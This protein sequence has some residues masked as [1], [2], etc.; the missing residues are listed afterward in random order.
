MKVAILNFFIIDEELFPFLSRVLPVSKE[1]N[2]RT[3]VMRTSSTL[4]LLVIKQGLALDLFSVKLP[5]SLSCRNA[6]PYRTIQLTGHHAM[7]LEAAP[8]SIG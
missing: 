5:M 3:T 1:I 7:E 8:F 2:K 6:D 4:D